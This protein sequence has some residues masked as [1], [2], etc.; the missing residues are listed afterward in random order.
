MKLRL[1]R[2][3]LA[4]FFFSLLTL[5]FL[6]VTGWMPQYLFILAKF[7]FIPAL[8]SGMVGIVGFLILLTLLF[9]RV[10]CSVLC[11]LGISMDIITWIRKRFKPKMKYRFSSEKRVLRLCVLV[12]VIVT[13][14]LGV[15]VV[16]SLLDPY[17]GFG[18]IATH[19]FRPVYLAGHNALVDVFTASGNETLLSKPII[20]YSLFSF[21]IAIAT[22][23]VIGVFAA[24]YGRTW[25]N[26]I[27]P[28]GTV[29]GYLSK[30]SLFK[31]RID[32]T[33]C[34][35]CG[36]CERVCKA[37]C[38][39]NKNK[40][41][42]DTRC[43]A[44]FD[45]LETCKFSSLSYGLP[46]KKSVTNGPTLASKRKAVGKD[47]L[48]KATKLKTEQIGAPVDASRRRFMGTLAAITTAAAGASVPV[49]SLAQQLS[50]PAGRTLYKKKHPLSPPG[51]ISAE[52][53]LNKC[54]AC[55]LC[56]SK[57]PYDVLKPSLL[58]YGLGGIMQ[59][60]M[61]FSHGYCDYDCTIC[62]G[63]CPNEALISMSVEEKHR[64][65]MGQVVFIQNNCV[66]V[67]DG[68]D[69]GLCSGV[70]P[71]QAIQMVPYRNYLSIPSVNTSICVGCGGCEYICPAVPIKAMQ[72]EG[73]PIHLK[74]VAL[75]S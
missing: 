74:A 61:S 64:L 73:N 38:I 19:L 15:T 2:T 37:S 39:D 71:T 52:H 45:C 34:I 41:V 54:T 63:V 22:L 66:V 24:L 11:P 10:Y 29:L 33:S 59:P 42:D 23:L 58:E 27:C 25:C 12:V 67:T 57:C 46:R 17:A 70:C 36:K 1:L 14:F 30:F 6:D 32:Q 16:L 8:L 13:Y 49:L 44:C 21:I 75:N 9:S 51:S 65:Q 50:V 47:T 20:L 3:I 5:Y 55:H 53:L 28:V 43:V 26:T 48:V 72:V 62:S 18:R 35:S 4:I 7:Q 40:R 69:C 31:I 60:V 56:V 68:T